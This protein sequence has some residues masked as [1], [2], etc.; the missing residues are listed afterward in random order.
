LNYLLQVVAAS[1]VKEP[2]MSEVRSQA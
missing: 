1:S 2:A